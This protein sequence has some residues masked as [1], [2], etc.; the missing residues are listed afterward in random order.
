M[1]RKLLR[2]GARLAVGS[3]LAVSVQIFAASVQGADLR[4]GVARVDLTPPDRLQAPLGGYGERM[5]APAQGVHDRIFA[6]A[7][8]LTDGDK[9]FV[10]VTADMLGFPPPLKQDLLNRLSDQGWTTENVMLL[11]SHSHASIEMNA[12]NPLNTFAI[13]QLGI[14]NPELYEFTVANFVRL[15]REAEQN[16]IPIRVGTSSKHLPG[17]NRNRRHR[18]GIVDDELTIT[19][20]DS[21][22][23]KPMALLVNFTAHPTFMTEK[24]MM[25]SGGWPGHLQRTAEGLIGNGVTVMYYNGAEGDQRP[26]GRPNGGGSRWEQ[27]ERYGHELGILVRQEWQ[28]IAM[29]NDVAF[30][31]HHQTISL[32]DRSWHPD[33][34]KTGGTEYGLTEEVLTV[35]LPQ[36]FPAQTASGSLQL[37][38]LVVVG[39]PGEMAASLGLKIK[40]AARQD[41]GITHPVIGGLADEWISYMLPP[42]EYD[43]GG[44]EASVSFYGRTLGTVIV[45]GAISGL[46]QLDDH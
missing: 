21:T 29:Q 31:F 11:A 4:G 26:Q 23:G 27:A 33:F 5:N 35:M 24:Q 20:I 17:W 12:I 16:L 42:Q 32:P 22:A 8:V 3:I 40:A 7:I 6:K 18:S 28:S 45:E 10:L 19:R 1:K 39:I 37:G 14:H 36:M 41:L 9:K 34:M 2:W 13:P 25:F 30:Q 44:Y 46:N 43:M 38:E 15:I